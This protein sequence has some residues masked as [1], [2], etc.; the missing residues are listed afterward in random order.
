MRLL[1]TIAWI[2]R[3]AWKPVPSPGVLGAAAFVA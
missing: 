3:E 2:N 1:D